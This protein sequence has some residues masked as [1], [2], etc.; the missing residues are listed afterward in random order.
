[1]PYKP[2]AKTPCVIMLEAT[3]RLACT[4]GVSGEGRAE[5]EKGKERG[6]LWSKQG[7]KG[8]RGGGSERK[9]ETGDLLRSLAQ[10]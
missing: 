3:T 10:D 6:K 9:S 5:G 2:T 4:A 1:M 7:G 8:E